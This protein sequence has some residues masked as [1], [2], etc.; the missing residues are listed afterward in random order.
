MAKSN[1]YFNMDMLV[2]SILR[3]EDCYGYDIVKKIHEISDSAITIKEGTLY[4]IMYTLLKK[5]FITSRDVLVNKKV[6]VYYHLEQAGLDYLIRVSQEFKLNIQG[7][8]KVL[9]YGEGK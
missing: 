5:E 1:S 3:K 9:E 7:V 8:F 6:R 2:L 4:P